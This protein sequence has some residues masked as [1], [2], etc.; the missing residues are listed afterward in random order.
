M[1]SAP[2]FRLKNLMEESKTVG[3]PVTRLTRLEN[4]EWGCF[5]PQ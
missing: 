2:K 5:F 4:E 1:K 3:K